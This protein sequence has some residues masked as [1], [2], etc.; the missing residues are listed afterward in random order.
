MND[1][2]KGILFLF[3]YRKLWI[4]SL[5]IGAAL[6][7]GLTFI[8][9]PKY[10]STAIVYPYNSQTRDDLISN[11]QFGYEVESEQL[12]Q[13]LNSKSM[14]DRTIK[15]FKLYEYY[16]IDT[17]KRSWNSE[18]TRRYVKD[19]VFLRSKFLSVVINV[20][21]EDPELAA[22]VANY[23][24]EEVDRYR[25]SIFKANRIADLEKSKA[26]MEKNGE[27]LQE[28]QDS[29]Y[30]VKG[31]TDAL[32]F[33]FI[34]NLNN[35][36]YNP[37]DFVNTP[38]LEPLIVDYKFAYN[39][40]VNARNSYDEKKQAM[41]DPIPTVYKVDIA[42]PSYRAVSPSFAINTALGALVF[43]MVV[44]MVR[45]FIDKW[46]EIKAELPK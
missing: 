27:T 26:V 6:G 29:I 5:I 3:K 7:C 13:L 32:L 4:L 44:F 12:M 33:N 46:Q 36:E 38:E 25:A 20:T 30:L 1:N 21:L 14:R 9:S 18:I 22:N 39:K 10:M 35:D 31:G 34:E 24:V 37:S 17:N 41:E 42:Q 8:M 11:P 43:F 15:K 45:Y 16:D 40:Y 19:V 28:L 2:N 23:Q